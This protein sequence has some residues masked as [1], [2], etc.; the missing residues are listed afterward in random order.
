MQK[1]F[2]KQIAQ[3]YFIY[4][5]FLLYSEREESIVIVK[6]FNFRLLTDLRVL[7]CPERELVIFTNACLSVGLSLC[8]QIL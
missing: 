7:K 4:F 8:A 3:K 6:I 2:P 5:Y 1:I